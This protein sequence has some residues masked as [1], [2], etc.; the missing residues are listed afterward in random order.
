MFPYIKLTMRDGDVIWIRYDTIAQVYYDHEEKMTGI[1]TTADEHDFNVRESVD[2][3]INKLKA[4]YN[5]PETDQPSL[6]PYVTNP[7]ST[8]PYDPEPTI[9]EAW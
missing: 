6:Q 9:K 3:V 2:E 4:F 1:C 5:Q 7:Y 8:N